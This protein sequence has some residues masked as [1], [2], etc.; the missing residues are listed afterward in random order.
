M[1]LARSRRSGRTRRSQ[2]IRGP[3][4]RAGEVLAAIEQ[5]HCSLALLDNSSLGNAGKGTNLTDSHADGGEATWLTEFITEGYA[6]VALRVAEFLLAVRHVD[7]LPFACSYPVEDVS[8]GELMA[9]ER[10]NGV[11]RL[12]QFGPDE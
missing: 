4:G 7:V 6:W 5:G 10:M 9:V 11:G 2:D 1:T 12:D 8:F 3:V